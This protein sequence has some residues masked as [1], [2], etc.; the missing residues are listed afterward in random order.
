MN[1]HNTT[2][3]HKIRKIALSALLISSLT[4]SFAST[5]W[6]GA[7]KIYEYDINGRLS[8]TYTTTEKTTFTYD[9]NGN[10]LRKHVEKGD[11]SSQVNPAGT[12]AKATSVS[13]NLSTESFDTASASATENGTDTSL[14]DPSITPPPVSIPSKQG[15]P[16]RSKL[17]RAIYEQA[18]GTIQVKGWYLD[19]IGIAQ[20]Q[21]YVDGVDVG[22]ANM[23]SERS[24]VNQ[25]YPDYNNP[26]AGFDQQGIKII[27]KGVP[28]KE[29]DKV[30]GKMKSVAGAV[31]HK[32]QVLIV[33]Q[34]GEKTNINQVLT[35][36]LN[37]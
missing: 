1:K 22:R 36:Y 19:P 30:T 13:T 2:P 4:L 26:L 17:H 12:I 21:I 15:L 16:I 9:A 31:D 33:N 11:Y 10:L 35:V 3:I 7:S 28:H 5:T 14:L 34:K 18:T 24:D 6:A 37:R 32:I 29:K 8:T 20:V 23:G 27:T 25:A